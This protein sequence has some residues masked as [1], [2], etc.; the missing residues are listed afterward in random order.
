MDADQ[1]G[2]HEREDARPAFG[3]SGSGGE[4]RGVFQ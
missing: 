4:D 2:V 1:R 3:Q